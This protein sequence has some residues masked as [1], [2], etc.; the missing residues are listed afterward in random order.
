MDTDTY[1]VSSTKDAIV[2]STTDR[3]GVIANE[4]TDHLKRSAYHA[5]RVGQLLHEAKNLLLTDSEFKEWVNGT[6]IGELSW[7]TVKN[8]MNL[9][10]RFTHEQIQATPQN[11]LSV[12][13]QL[14]LPSTPDFVVANVVQSIQDG[15]RLTNEEVKDLIRMGKFIEDNAP[16]ILKRRVA[17][18][19]LSLR[20]AYGI[21]LQ[22][23]HVP[24]EVAA[25]ALH[26]NVSDASVI[27][28]LAEMAKKAPEEFQSVVA[29]GY[30]QQGSGDPIPLSEATGR[31]ASGAYTEVKTESRKRHGVASRIF[32]ALCEVKSVKEMY[33][34]VRVDVDPKAVLSEGQIARL[35]LQDPEGLS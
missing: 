8:F 24:T 27:K 12:M 23:Q 30:I 15:A 9:Y 35:I 7:P 26:H 20:S 2:Q 19:E 3:L 34:T 32:D 11:G 4:I 28:V 18:G 31:E 6:P 13:Y 16:E 17:S 5:W 33:I 25:A 21:A 1:T 22:C 14:A 29:T 10:T